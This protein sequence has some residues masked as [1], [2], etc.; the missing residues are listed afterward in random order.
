M[1]NHEENY[2]LEQMST[3]EQAARSHNQRLLYQVVRSLAPKSRRGRPPL[4]DN[5]GQMMTRSEEATCFHQ[6]FTAKFTAGDS[7]MVAL[8]YVEGDA[9][10]H[11]HNTSNTSHAEPQLTPQALENQLSRAPLRKAVPPNYPPSSIWRLCSDIVA[12][13]VSCVIEQQW[14]ATSK[15]VPQHWSDAHLVLIR[16]PAKTGKE[17]GHYRPIGLQDQLGKLTFKALLEPH[18]DTIYALTTRYPQYGYTPGR[19]HRDALRRVFDHCS[20]V[21]A[22]CRAQHSTLHDKFAGTSTSSEDFVGGIQVTRDLAAAFDTMPRHRLLEGMQRMQLPASL[23]QTVMS[24]QRHASYH[25]NHDGTVRTI[26]ATQ[27]VRQGCAAAPLLWLI[28]SHLVSEKLAEKI[29]YQAIVE[30]LSIFADDYHCSGVFHSVWDI[31][32]IL[33]RVHILL[34]TLKE[35]GMLVSPTKSK[36]IFKCAGPGSE[37]LRRQLVRKTSNGNVLRIR[38][39][40]DCIDI[41]LVESFTYLGAIVSYDHFEDRTLTYR[42]EVGSSNFGRLSRILRGRHALTRRHKVRIWQAC[43]Y[44]ATVYSLDAC[45]LTPQ[46]AKRLTGQLMRQIRLIVRDPVYM[47]G[48]PHNTVLEEWG[49]LSP[50]AALRRQLNHEPSEDCMSPDV[51][52]RGPGSLAWQRVMAT[53]IDPPTSSLVE[54]PDHSNEGVPCPECGVYFANRTSMLPHMS[55]KHKS[56]E[57]RPANQEEHVFDKHKD[58]KDGLPQCKHCQVKLCDFSSLRKHINERRCKVLFPV[59]PMLPP[60]PHLQTTSDT[61]TT[62]EGKQEQPPTTRQPAAPEIDAKTIPQDYQVNLPKSQNL[63]VVAQGAELEVQHQGQ[64][65]LELEEHLPYYCRTRVQSL[66]ATHSENAAFHLKD[67]QWLRQHCALCSQWIACHTKV[68]QHYRLS[69]QAEFEAHAV[70]A[71]HLCARFNTPASPCEHCGV[72]VKAYRQHPSKCSVLWQISLMSLKL[73]LGRSSHGTTTGDVRTFGGRPAQHDGLGAEQEGSR[74]GVGP[75]RSE[76]STTHGTR[77]GAPRTCGPLKQT[78]LAQSWGKGA[79]I[80]GPPSKPHGESPGKASASARNSPQNPETGLQ[81]GSVCPT[82]QSGSSSTP[83]RCPQK[84]KKSGGGNH[85]NSAA[86]LAAWV[87]HPNAAHGAEGY[88]GRNPDPIPEKGRGNEMAAGCG[89]DQEPAATRQADGSTVGSA[90]ADNAALHDS[91]FSRNQA[92]YGQNDR[93]HHLPAR[94]VQPNLRAPQ[95]VGVPGSNDGPDGASSHR[96][97]TQTR[98]SQAVTGCRACA[99]SIGRML[100][101][102][103]LNSSNTCYINASARAWLY[104]VSHLQVADILKYGHHEQAWRDVYHTR[105]P[106]HVHALQSWRPLLRNWANLH[107]QQDAGEFLEHLMGIC[108]PQVLQPDRSFACTF[109]FYIF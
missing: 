57:A 62:K 21:R 36:A 8:Q 66:L 80:R 20:S 40:N 56:H 81:L 82:W 9:K 59:A 109:T 33:S 51:F 48:K 34:N 53:L 10:H 58:A 97:S 99:T 25:I 96:T 19:S 98:F 13:K 69:H 6:R 68:K 17:A 11:D 89:R 3:A 93:D 45:G 38:S 30:L 73:H 106:I 24:W 77:K 94:C 32:Q 42:L 64:E 29:G 50:I 102:K 90:A 28:F 7:E 100:L 76:Q 43:V 60:P 104:T 75:F 92:P 49:L 101:I 18:R 71:A 74:Q 26:Q 2:I 86:H 44:T 87:S 108:Q 47:T 67:C 79:P 55:K 88:L 23:I 12:E 37:M 16:K 4:R 46:G 27:G 22:Q 1:S 39:A 61:N 70:E 15:V 95:A 83:L 52:K 72:T 35:M 85:H 105:K 91:P 14:N 65:P 78:T 63:P 41:P 54:L 107:M 31:E 84:W 5:Q 103:L